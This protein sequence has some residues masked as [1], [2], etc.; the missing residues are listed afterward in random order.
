[1]EKRVQLQDKDL[2]CAEKSCLILSTILT[3]FV[4]PVVIPLLVSYPVTPCLELILKTRIHPTTLQTVELTL[5]KMEHTREELSP[6]IKSS[7]GQGLSFLLSALYE[8][9]SLSLCIIKC[10]PPTLCNFFLCS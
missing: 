6:K 2:I 7:K 10:L 1:M 8:C 5:V 3:F 9:F 4:L